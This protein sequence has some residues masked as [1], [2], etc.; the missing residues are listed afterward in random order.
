MKRTPPILAAA[1]ALLALAAAPLATAEITQKEGVRVS[2][3]GKMTPNTLPRN[4]TAPIAVSVSG[5]IHSSAPA[6]P[7]QLQTMTIAINSHGRLATGGIPR[8]HAGRIT[9]ST[10]AQ[11]RA[12]CGP[13]LIGEGTFSAHVT[14]PEQSPFPSQGKVLAFNGRLAGRPAIFAHIYGTRPVPTSYTLPFTIRSA[15]G[16]YGTI[17]EAS[18]PQVTGQW[19][20][21]TGI[22]ITLSRTFTSHGRRLSYLSAGCPAP[23]GFKAAPFPL[24]RTSFSF[25]GGLEL[26]T[27]LNRSCKVRG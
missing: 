12:A 10:T 4:G 27:I 3:G 1:A 22:S 17:L 6:G 7:P 13:S 5:Q 24:L 16:T 23:P 21:V 8:C 15:K 14:Y 20:F 25:A 11:A 18:F 9:P 2:V 19:G 26:T